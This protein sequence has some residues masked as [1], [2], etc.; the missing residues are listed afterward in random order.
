MP[1]S[2]P[3]AIAVLSALAA[4]TPSQFVWDEARA[5]GLARYRQ[6]FVEACGTRFDAAL[7]ADGF[8]A[9]AQRTQLLWLGD[10]HTDTDQH[11]R[12]AALLERLQRGPRGLALALE[13]IAIEDEP[14]VA[15][16]LAG[17]LSMGSLRQRVRARWPGSWLDDPALDAEFYCWLLAFAREHRLPVVA[18]EGVPRPPLEMRDAAIAARVEAFAAA[19]HDR[20]V[21]AIVGQAHLVGEG[22]LVARCALPQV[23]LGGV[24]PPALAAAAPAAPSEGTFLRSDGGLWWFAGALQR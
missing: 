14:L 3:V 22:A 5:A 16:F 18:L 6:S 10:Y 12:I 8:A 13:S 24:P 21:V 9:M 20:L 23:V 17:E 2:R 1:A 7:D 19:S 4:C 15:S 11:A